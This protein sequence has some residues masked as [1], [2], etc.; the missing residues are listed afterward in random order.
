MKYSGGYKL[1]ISTQIIMMVL[2]ASRIISIYI[3]GH[4]TNQ[5]DQ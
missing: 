5:K 1:I 2:T 4:W 3:L